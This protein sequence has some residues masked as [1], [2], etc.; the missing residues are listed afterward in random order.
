MITCF[1]DSG[2]KVVGFFLKK[3]EDITFVL[4]S[5]ICLQIIG[6]LLSERKKNRNQTE[7]ISQK[8]DLIHL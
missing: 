1:R 5:E 8:G 2:H 4:L 6:D 3:P 7:N